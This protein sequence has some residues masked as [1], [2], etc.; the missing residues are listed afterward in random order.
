MLSTHIKTYL[1]KIWQ[2]RTRFDAT[3]KGR[4]FDWP[5][6]LLNYLVHKRRILLYLVRT[7]NRNEK[8]FLKFWTYLFHI[9]LLNK[10]FTL[11]VEQALPLLSVHLIEFW[12]FYFFILLYKE[13]NWIDIFRII[14]TL[15]KHWIFS[16]SGNMASIGMYKWGHWFWRTKV[17]ILLL[18]F[19]LGKIFKLFVRIYAR[20]NHVLCIQYLIL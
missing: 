8:S 7:S 2:W 20:L 6:K 13:Y 14:R 4:S 5:W 19:I 3:V 16:I 11:I 9:F 10:T 15:F 17:G 12:G 1:I 18:V